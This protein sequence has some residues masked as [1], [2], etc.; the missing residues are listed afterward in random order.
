[1]LTDLQLEELKSDN[2]L[3][4]LELEDIQAAINRK[5]QEIAILRT[6]AARVGELQSKLEMGLYAFE[7][8]QVNLGQRNQEAASFEKRM[9]D[10]EDE[11]YQSVKEQLA[12]AD[13]LKAMNSI[14]ANLEYAETELQESGN[15]Y[16]KLQ[17][18]ES[19]LAECNSKSSFL[20]EEN[21]RLKREIDEVFELNDLLKK[22]FPGEADRD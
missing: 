2:E 18:L 22:Q 9:A 4:R 20:E 14:K 19:S 3:L 17:D 8:M 10:M 6:E 13:K 11:L 21:K 5:E 15:V 1:M 16:K 12:Y 7:Q